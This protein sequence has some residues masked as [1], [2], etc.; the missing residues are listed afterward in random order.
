MPKNLKSQTA[1]GVAP[2][3]LMYGVPEIENSPENGAGTQIATE[4]CSMAVRSPGT[5]GKPGAETK[6]IHPGTPG[7]T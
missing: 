3:W 5:S 7:E 6:W 1:V 4:A 2:R